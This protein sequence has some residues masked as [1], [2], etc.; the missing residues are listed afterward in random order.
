[1]KNSYKSIETTNTTEKNGRDIIKHFKKE[2]KQK[3]NKHITW[4]QTS[5]VIKKFKL[6]PS[7]LYTQS[8]E[9][10]LRSLTLPDAIEVVSYALLV[11]TTILENKLTLFYKAEQLNIMT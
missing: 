8:C 7:P 9:Q 4:Y 10:K 1:M 6:S 5:Q 2:D 3:M 11:G